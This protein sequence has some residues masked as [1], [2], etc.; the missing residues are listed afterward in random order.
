MKHAIIGCGTV[1][2]NHVFGMRFA[3]PDIILVCCDKDKDKVQS[4]AEKHNISEIHTDYREILRDTSVE[5]VSICTDHGSHAT[6]TLDALNAGKHV[7]VEKPMALS[8]LDS[9]RMIAA[10]VANNRI[11]SVISQHR[12]TP[13]VQYIISLIESGVFGEIVTIS[14]TLNSH[15]DKSY[16]E[17]SYWRGTLSGEGGS[18]LI[19]QAI[20]TLDLMINI[21]GQPTDVVAHQ[22]N[23]KFYD[24]ETEDTIAGI[25]K[26]N[27][28]ALGTILSTNASSKFWDSKIEIVATKGNIS[29]TTE[30]PLKVTS[31]Y[32]SDL[33]QQQRIERDLSYYESEAAKEVPPSRDYYGISHKYQIKNFLNATRNIEKLTVPPREAQNTLK[34]VLD[35]YRSSRE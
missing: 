11:L 32:M 18:T 17:D 9:D 19:N 28:G 5:S 25:F 26:F 23:L 1:A 29:F 30:F 10:S 3:D 16:Y 34:A 24:I 12:Y 4:F 2:P 6:I 8:L 21:M 13:E 27:N 31:L 14:G 22:A 20:H 7:L 15:K 35:I 33:V